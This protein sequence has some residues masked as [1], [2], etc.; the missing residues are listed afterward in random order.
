MYKNFINQQKY[1]YLNILKKGIDSRK[2]GLSW[3]VKKLIELNIIL[4]DSIFPNFLDLNEIQFL[5]LISIL[6]FECF[7]IEIVI[8]VFK[9]RQN[10]N[11]KNDD[12]NNKNYFYKIVKNK[13]SNNK[14]FIS[15]KINKNFTNVYFKYFNLMNKNFFNF[16]IENDKIKNFYNEIKKKINNFAFDNNENNFNFNNDEYFLNIVKLNKKKKEI[17][18]IILEIVKEEQK[19]FEEKY[20]NLKN[21]KNKYLNNNNKENNNNY[22]NEYYNKK[23]EALFGKES[24]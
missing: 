20:S 3:V 10:K 17:E 13:F 12:F 15:N 21:N 8:D 11:N 1:Y 7:L 9:Q 5:K 19:I 18:K 22:Y 23:Y 4:D 2:E 6:K 16:K 24:N 14:N